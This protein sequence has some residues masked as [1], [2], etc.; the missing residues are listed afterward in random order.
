MSVGALNFTLEIRYRNNGISFA[1][2]SEKYTKNIII[3]YKDETVETNRNENALGELGNGPVTTITVQ[4]T[5]DG[6]QWKGN[7]TRI[8]HICMCYCF[9]ISS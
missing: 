7:N 1:R 8:G 3:A 5:I 2:V 6:V 4:V 9:E